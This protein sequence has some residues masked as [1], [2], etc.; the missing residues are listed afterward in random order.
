MM[1]YFIVGF[2]AGVLSMAAFV[3][4]L[5]LFGRPLHPFGPP[6]LPPQWNVPTKVT[7]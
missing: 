1:E 6:P 5:L 4:A 7:E 3:V 2:A